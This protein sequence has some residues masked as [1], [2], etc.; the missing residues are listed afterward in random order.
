[1]TDLP[2][3]QDPRTS[4]EPG[5]AESVYRESEGLGSTDIRKLDTSVAEWRHYR[6][7]GI[8]ETDAMELGTL[9]HLAVLEP[10]RFEEEIVD[11]PAPPVDPDDLSRNKRALAGLMATHSGSLAE[12]ASE[13]SVK[14]S[15]VVKWMQRPDLQDLAQYT[16][17]YGEAPDPEKVETA[18]DIRDRLFRHP[19]IEG[20][21]LLSGADTE[22][23]FWWGER[24]GD[25]TWQ[26]KGR[27]DALREHGGQNILVDIKTTS[28]S[29]KTGSYSRTI[30]RRQYFVQGGHYMRGIEETT[31]KRVAQCIF[32]A[33]ESDPPH[34]INHLYLGEEAMRAGEEKQRKALR[35]LTEWHEND[36]VW[37][38]IEPR[39]H[40]A[41]L[42]PWE[43]E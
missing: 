25:V 30:G 13:V 16:A 41:D 4:Y 36:D 21:G 23:S 19:L 20:D 10:E 18:I 3:T 29:V 28:R 9:I 33:I 34:H 7:E 40:K 31:G 38:G 26:C 5:T 22:C 35:D 2:T 14:D 1:M 11:R 6:E 12:L 39:L 42:K 27:A 32:I 43:L 17:E 8:D 15:T 37:D 24:A